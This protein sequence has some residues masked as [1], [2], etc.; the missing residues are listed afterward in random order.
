MYKPSDTTYPYKKQIYSM[1]RRPE[2]NGNASGLRTITFGFSVTA[3]AHRLPVSAARP[4]QSGSLFGYSPS[5]DD[6]IFAPINQ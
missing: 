5:C 3:S 4:G 2:R 1:R 6:M